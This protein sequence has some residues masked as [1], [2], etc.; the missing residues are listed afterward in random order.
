M[1]SAALLLHKRLEDSAVNDDVQSALTILQ[2][3]REANPS[4]KSWVN[5]PLLNQDGNHHNISAI[6]Y[7]GEA[8]KTSYAAHFPCAMRLICRMR[9]AGLHILYARIAVLM[10][11]DVLRPHVDTYQTVRVLIPLNERGDDFRHLVGDECIRMR[12][13]DIWQINGQICHG[14]TNLGSQGTRIMLIIDGSPHSQL[15]ATW[16][17]PTISI[18]RDRVIRRDTSDR[19]RLWAD[20]H[21]LAAMGD[22]AEAERRWLM[23]PFEFTI[24]AELMYAELYNFS[25]AMAGCL[26]NEKDRDIWSARAE[27]MLH[28]RLPFE[29]EFALPATVMQLKNPGF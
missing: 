11:Q 5:F 19:Q 27:R 25:I 16:Y 6:P 22:E 28:S 4:L 21:E 2:R 9:E 23:A 8:R 18:P 13:G 29:I 10:P 3:L 1:I 26:S 15:P 20:A 24:T 7:E 17:G 12:L 14:A